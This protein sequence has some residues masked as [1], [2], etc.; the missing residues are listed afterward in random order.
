MSI[1]DVEAQIRKVADKIKR[2][3]GHA[4]GG[5]T[6]D[7]RVPN[8]GLSLA[9]A[10]DPGV[11]GSWSAVTP[12]D[13]VPI[14]QAVLP[15][16]KVLMWDS[17]GDGPAESYSTHTFT[18][19]MVWDPRTNTSVRRDVGGY[20]IFCA[21]Y[22]QLADGRVLVAGGNRDSGLNGIVQTLLFD[23]RTESWSR[24]PNMASGRWYRSVAALGND[25]AVIVGGGPAVPEVYQTNGTLRA[26]TG[27]PGCSARVYPFLVPRPDGKVE[28]VGPL[29]ATTTLDTS[30]A[31]AITARRTRD[32]LGRGYGT[33]ATL[34][35]GKVLVAGGGTLTEDGQTNVPTRTAVVVDVNGGTGVAPTG[36]MSVGRR[37]HNLTVLAH[38]SVL[39]TG[40]QSRS[41]DGQV[42]LE[43]P[44][45]AAERWNPVTGTW[46]VPA[47]ASR[48]REY[49]SSAR[50][51]PTGGCSPVAA[52]SAA[53]A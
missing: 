44:V 6:K 19:A 47:G 3:T 38:G 15:N 23:W 25:E 5:R 42:D 12:T 51:C 13:V 30:G 33:F 36:S 43:R 32:G 9:A 8:A 48:V 35:T 31:G 11:G 46:T 4:P 17:V 27:A 45:F 18:R 2:D 14:F 22:T 21:S 40:G 29:H 50:C 7:Q 52:A 24:G 41:V 37:Q 20:N 34:G 53:T 1:T 39:A 49:H 16:G 28:T 26:L 10:A